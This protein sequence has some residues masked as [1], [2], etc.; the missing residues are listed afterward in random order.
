MSFSTPQSAGS[1]GDASSDS[2]FVSPGTRRQP[3]SACGTPVL[4]SCPQNDDE[5]ERKQ[6]RRSRVFDLQFSTESP[7]S[8]Q[9]PVSKQAETSLPA[10]PHLSNT[11]IADHYST[12]IKLS[13][14]NKITTKNAFGLHLIDYMTEILRQKDS[15]LT[16][17]KVAAGTLDASTKI[18]AVRVDAV[19]ADVYRVLGGLGRD[20]AAA[21]TENS[22]DTGGGKEDLEQSKKRPIK[23]KHLYKTIEQNLNNINV[24]ETDR[25]C[26][27]DPMF[28]KTA[29]SFD[30]CSRAGVF[31][32]TLHTHSHLSEVL[33]DS[34]VVPLPSSA[35]SEMPS[36]SLV[37]VT[38]L[39]PILLR[40][41]EKS[42][43]CPSLSGFLFT[44]WN[45]ETHNESV[46]ALL[47]KFKKSDQAFDINAKADNDPQEFVEDRMEDDFDADVLD[48]MMARDLGKFSEKLEAHC[49]APGHSREK[50]AS[51]REGDIG[52]MC[53]QLSMNPSEYSYFSPRIM[54][55]WA[56]PEHWHFKPRH[57]G[58]ANPE[59]V[60][61]RKTIKKAF[62][63]NF[64]E[65]IDFAVYFRK[66]RAAT[67]LAKS[68]LESQNK[69]SNTLPADFHYNPDNLTRLFLKPQIRLSKMSLQGRSPNHDDDDEVGEYDY[70]NPND[71]SN[72]CPA[73]QDDDSDDENSPLNFIGQGGMFEMTANPT[74]GED[75]DRELDGKVKGLHIST[76][77][78]ANMV[79]EPQ[80]VNKIDIQ[81]AKTAKK[82][83]MKKLKQTMWH[84]L[85]EVPKNQ[86]KEESEDPE[87]KVKSISVGGSKAFSSITTD[88]LHR[89]P[90]VMAK[91]LSVPLAFACLLQ[92]ANEKNLKLQ[93]VQD[94][95]EV[96][97]LQE[98]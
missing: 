38:D 52:S 9:S 53:L 18:Y 67:V 31:L 14:E 2:Q 44:Q 43:I 5:R 16:N 36:S 91:N 17:F 89:L 6:R 76:Y 66:T 41:V 87:E 88:L 23:R 71:T 93:G 35:T 34:M 74:G 90:S 48:K 69:K 42:A 27:S 8:I 24:S 95:S 40:C 65:E 29:S 28:Q 30:E 80:K 57:K 11:Q 12:C 96:L 55:M 20:S 61:K 86:V 73:V 15:E 3:L 46:S 84:L 56:G 25:K 64:D 85:T 54:S 51:V 60:S 59:K 49:V 50:L 81:Y 92:L 33:F 37:S 78:E 58:D 4:Q 77:G 1:K 68:T 26:E 72:F 10:I 79:A 75:Q 13:T 70:N 97:V 22:Q 94:L 47:D 21:E 62:Q 39:K 98:D 7:L 32:I 82:M 45:S 83:D 63:I 19:H